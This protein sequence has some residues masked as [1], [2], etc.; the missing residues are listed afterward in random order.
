MRSM[1]FVAR[2]D[3]LLFLFNVRLLVFVA[4]VRAIPFAQIKTQIK[5]SDLSLSQRN[6]A[7][8]TCSSNAGPRFKGRMY[9]AIVR[10]F[11]WPWFCTGCA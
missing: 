2:S 7:A 8:I 9:A 4:S 3:T 6:A 1:P 10:K 11:C 5:A